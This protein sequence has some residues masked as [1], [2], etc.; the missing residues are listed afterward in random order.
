[1][2][3]QCLGIFYRS[4]ESQHSY[5]VQTDTN[6]LIITPLWDAKE[7]LKDCVAP[8]VSSWQISGHKSQ[9]LTFLIYG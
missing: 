5:I 6:K 3:A 4:S 7:A 8:S 1:M 2:L 9:S